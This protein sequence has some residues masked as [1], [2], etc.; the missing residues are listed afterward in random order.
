MLAQAT[1]PLEA[2]ALEHRH[3][4]VVQERRGDLPARAVLRIALDRAAP[5]AR[6]L[7]QRA[8]E[9]GGGDPS[10]PVLAIDEE[11]RDPPIR[12]GAQPG[13]V[14]AP[15]LDPRQLLGRPE[16]APAHALGPIEHEGRMCAAF[17]D[18][19][20]LLGAVLRRRLRPPDALDVEA[21][22]PAAAPHAVVALDQA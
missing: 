12:E 22:A 20:L 15:V 7:V 11:A 16:L 9:R 1:G 17:E 14:G 10:A 18:P 4:A 19:S 2:M 13:L 3:G 5:K 8:L 6:D 21:H